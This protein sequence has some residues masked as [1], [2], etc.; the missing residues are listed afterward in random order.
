MRGLVAILIISLLLSVAG[1]SE[2][3]SQRNSG[4]ASVPLTEETPAVISVDA[5][6]QPLEF[7]TDFISNHTYDGRVEAAA[8]AKAKEPR[9]DLGYAVYSQ[10]F[11]ERFGYPET[12][13]VS[14]LDR[15]VWLMEY[16][17]RSFGLYNHCRLRL[18]VDDVSD[19]F[20]SA[21]D[22]Y[23]TYYHDDLY[24]GPFRDFGMP[25]RPDGSPVAERQK[26]LSRVKEQHDFSHLQAFQVYYKPGLR[27]EQ[28]VV[29]AGSLNLNLFVRDYVDGLHLIDVTPFPCP[30]GT[31][32][33][34]GMANEIGGA[35]IAKDVDRPIE[36]RNQMLRN[37]ERYDEFSPI[38]IPKKMKLFMRTNLPEGSVYI[39]DDGDYR[40]NLSRYL[41]SLE[42]NH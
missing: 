27:P 12:N 10:A 41:L 8:L 11:S 39:S 40:D 6:E 23:L 13:V 33:G 1:C 32:G 9:F 37:P 24:D 35:W 36:I 20:L 19:T 29:S 21:S 22:G 42:Q 34:T 14:D 7:R 31:R 26:W 25:G 2:S 16:R 17:F 30:T 5:L 4:T 38:R 15:N 18:L 3:S 28:T